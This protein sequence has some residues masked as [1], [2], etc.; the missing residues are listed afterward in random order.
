MTDEVFRCELGS[1]RPQGR[2]RAIGWEGGHITLW[3]QTWDM[4]WNDSLGTDLSVI[5]G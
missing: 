2:F 5:Y 1:G 4:K 3:P